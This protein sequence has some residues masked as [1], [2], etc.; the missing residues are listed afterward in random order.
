MFFEINPY[1][2]D[3]RLI[4]ETA[5][6]LRKGNLAIIPTYSVY[7]VICDLHHKKA[8]KALSQS[9]NMNITKIGD[10]DDSR[11]LKIEGYDGTRNSYQHF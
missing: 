6:A 3:T 11:E 2:I 9:C 7:A 4:K 8:L 10:I 1:H 5:V